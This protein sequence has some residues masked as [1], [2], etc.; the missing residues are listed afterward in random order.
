MLKLAGILLL[1]TGCIGLGLNKVAEEKRHIREL[2]EMR[3]IVQRMQSEMEYGKRTLPEICLLFSR[4]MNEPYRQA[5]GEIFQRLEANDG[6]TLESIWNERMD[7][8]MDRLALKEEEKEILRNLPQQQGILD[9]TMQAADVGQS[10]D[11]LTRHIQQA[12]AEYGNKSKVIMSIS[13]M[14]GLF[15]VIL[16]L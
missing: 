8:C 11:I 2:R 12:Q 9:E 15:L 10:L 16:L 7:A 6:S 4:C 1:M 3:R 5:F 13:V 14:T